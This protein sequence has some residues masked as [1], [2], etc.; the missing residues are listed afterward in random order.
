M[1]TGEG[2]GAAG[3]PLSDL[4]HCVLVLLGAGYCVSEI[5]EALDLSLLEV[6]RQ[7]RRIRQALGVSS[8]KAAINLTLGSR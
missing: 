4:D 2:I 6:A 5:A 7:L 8:T 1:S 3:A